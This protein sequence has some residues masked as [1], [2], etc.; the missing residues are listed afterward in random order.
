MTTCL[1]LDLGIH[2]PRDLAASPETDVFAQRYALVVVHATIGLDWQRVLLRRQLLIDSREAADSCMS[3]PPSIDGTDG[4]TDGRTPDRYI[5]AYSQWRNDM[6]AAVSSDGGP[7]G[8]RGP[9][10]F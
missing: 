9:Q 8:G 6:V 3:L 4:R 2:E 10:Q 5:D 1:C 7:T